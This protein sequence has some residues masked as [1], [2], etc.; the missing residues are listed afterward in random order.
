MG[1][2]TLSFL[3]LFLPSLYILLSSLSLP[4]LAQAEPTN[5]A[6]SDSSYLTV[7]LSYLGYNTDTTA[8]LYDVMYGSSLKT[9]DMFTSLIIK[10]S[11]NIGYLV[12]ASTDKDHSNLVRQ[13]NNLNEQDAYINPTQS[14]YNYKTANIVYKSSSSARDNFT[15]DGSLSLIHI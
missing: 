7:N 1:L 15:I 11:Q 12:T 14:D 3:A 2:K 6:G 9:P 13:K 10:S 5:N 4:N 8:K